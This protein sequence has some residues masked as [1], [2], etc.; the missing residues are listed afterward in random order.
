M[1]HPVHDATFVVGFII[2][3]ALWMIPA[4]LTRAWLSAGGAASFCS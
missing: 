4:V 3:C 2:V 1:S